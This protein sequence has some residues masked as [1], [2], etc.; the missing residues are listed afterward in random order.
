MRQRVSVGLPVLAIEIDNG[1][2]SG[3]LVEAVDVDI[4]PVGV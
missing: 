1:H 3:L 4:N 2:R